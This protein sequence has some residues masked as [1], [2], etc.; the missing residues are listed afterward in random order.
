[1][2]AL[3][4]ILLPFVTAFGIL[5][6]KGLLARQLALM[7]SVFQLAVTLYAIFN[8]GNLLSPYQVAWMP[9]FGISFHLALDGLSLVMVLLTNLIMP[10]IVAAVD[11]SKLQKNASLLALM[12]LMQGAM[13]G[14][15]EA[16]D[17][18]LY[19]VFWELAL[20]PIYFILLMWGG[21]NRVKVTTKFFVY[22][23]T[24][25]LF[26]LIGLIMV[27]LQTPTRSWDITQMYAAQLN[28]F[29]QRIA[30]WCIFLAFAIKIPI[31]PFHT[32]QPKTY[33]Q[34]PTY[35]TM[36]LAGI[37]LK[38]GVYSLFRWL[39]PLTPLALDH[40]GIWIVTLAVI[41]VIYA[42]WIA[43]KQRD[44][45]TLLAYSS[46]GHVGLI[47]AGIFTQNEQGMQGAIFQSFSHGINVV[48]LFYIAHLIEKRTQ[49]RFIPDLGGIRNSA[50]WFSVLFLIIVLGAIAMPLT[51]G[52]VGEFLL[53]SGTFTYNQ[54]LGAIAGFSVILTAVYMLRMYQRV[55][56]GES[57]TITHNFAEIT[58]N[59]AIYL[60]P[61]AALTL[62][63]GL[64]PA[65]ILNMT[66]Q[67]VA[68][69]L[70]N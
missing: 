13:I 43:I 34:A 20:L 46:M 57:N 59:E 7:V 58:K 1:M 38:M 24:G 44:I 11:T 41:G 23:L 37:M 8:G 40:Y 21:E 30:F 33:T 31:F 22:T 14:V 54:V 29:D 62:V 18:F 36:L 56:L 27:Y 25:S 2:I 26:M 4:L 67:F 53:L 51:S 64:Y 50:P 35:G 49:T 65:P 16:Q 28:D 12:L 10:F 39:L 70:N 3:F 55:M 5:F 61:L 48:A 19:Y 60:L 15:F 6:T 69:L 63:L 52:F 42:S 47:A 32:W 9:D 66:A 17:A 45:K 68:Q